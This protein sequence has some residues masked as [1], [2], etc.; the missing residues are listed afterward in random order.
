MNT[1]R[2]DLHQTAIFYGGDYNPE[3]WPATVWR[4]D[5]RLMQEAGVNLATLGVFSWSKLEPQP[6]QY[7]FE[8]FDEIVA[9]LHE[10][11]IGI[12]LATA[13]ASPPLWLAKDHPESLPQSA[14]NVTVWPG[15]RQAYCPHSTAYREAA[16][17]LVRQLATRYGQHPAVKLWHINNEYACHVSECFCDVSAEAFRH[18]L[19]TRY[20]TLDALN[21]AWGAAFWSQQVGAW[22]EIVPPR[23]TPTFG[24]PTRQ[25]DW[26]RFS[27]D[28]LLELLLMEKAILR[29]LTPALPVTTNFIG[30]FKPLDYWEWARNED[31]VSNDMYPDPTDPKSGMIMALSSDLMRSLGDGR[32]WMLMEQTSSVVNW[33]PVNKPKLPGQMRLWSHQ[34][35]ARG[36]NAVLFFQWRASKA[37]A[38]KFHGALV[39][40][41][42]TTESRVWR[43]VTQLGDEL[44][45][46]AALIPGRV[47]AETAILIDWHSWWALEGE[48]HP[49]AEIQLVR[50]I[51][52]HYKPLFDANI[53]VDFAKPDS[54]LSRYKLV[55]VPNLHLV[56]AE[57]AAN[58]ERYVEQGGTV[59][60]SFFSGI[61]DEHDHI[62]LG[63]YPAPFRR[64]LGLWVEEFDPLQPNEQVTIQFND[65]TQ[66]Q[67]ALWSEV[68]HREGAEAVAQFVDGFAAGGTAIARHAFGK[69]TAWYFGTAPAAMD[70]LYDQILADA[71]VAAKILVP[72]GVETVFRQTDAATYLFLLNHRREAVDVALADLSGVDLLTDQPCVGQTRLEP[73]GVCILRLD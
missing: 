63:G 54:D 8:W 17:A 58:I 35:V 31:V 67:G 10:H 59:V 13:T 49:S 53:P 2:I 60:F 62:W 71:Q 3:Q 1:D 27:S 73:F 70:K 21:E 24:N 11:G 64:L 30:L 34:A 19:Q 44:S 69:G 41:A 37:G 33:R 39:Q 50:Q 48:A 29:E 23:R 52:S 28:S 20:G 68:I 9:L 6:G 40:H 32:P 12:C 5:M 65:G 42:G 72:E 43:E 15:S 47:V 7:D 25:L 4:E 38:E 57:A 46:L 22:D 55:I 66:T 51:E 61:V 45:R 56:T 18:W 16:A 14:D 36:A 26:R